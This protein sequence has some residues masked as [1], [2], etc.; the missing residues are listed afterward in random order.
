MWRNSG[1][2]GAT[3]LAKNSDLYEKHKEDL[4]QNLVP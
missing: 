2:M 1:G 3:W 4:L